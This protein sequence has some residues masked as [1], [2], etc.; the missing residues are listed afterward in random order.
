[1]KSNQTLEANRSPA[2]PL[3]AAWEFGRRSRSTLRFQRRSHSFAL[4]HYAHAS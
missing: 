4:G 2:S 1:M 3:D